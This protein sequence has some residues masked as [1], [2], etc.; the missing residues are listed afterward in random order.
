MNP[1]PDQSRQSR[2][3]RW[4]RVWKYVD[5]HFQSWRHLTSGKAGMRACVGWTRLCVLQPCNLCVNPVA[6][7]RSEKCGVVRVAY[8]HSTTLSSW[9]VAQKLD[10]SYVEI[11]MHGLVVRWTWWAE[12][13][14]WAMLRL[15]RVSALK[16]NPGTLQWEEEQYPSSILIYSSSERL[17]TLGILPGERVN[18]GGSSQNLGSFLVSLNVRC[19]I[20]YIIKRAYIFWE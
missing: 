5:F 12:F 4:G 11:G 17:T 18:I 14:S 3:A 13:I 7:V 2:Y 8:C 15:E 16:A 1:G 9:L 19:G 6:E 20:L 10:V